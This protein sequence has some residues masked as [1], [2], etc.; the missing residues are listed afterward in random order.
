MEA[1]VVPLVAAV[2]HR[3]GVD[4]LLAEKV[5]VGGAVGDVAVSD[6]AAA[7]DD[8]VWNLRRRERIVIPLDQLLIGGTVAILGRR[9]GSSP[10]IEKRANAAPHVGRIVASDDLLEAAVLH[11]GTD[12]TR[13]CRPA[14]MGQ[15]VAG[16]REWQ[17]KTA[18]GVESWITA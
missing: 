4:V 18:R 1:L 14:T 8:P 12:V 3:G 13:N 2:G 7:E 6:H 17:V 15:S 16:R 10:R 5:G 9:L 11:P